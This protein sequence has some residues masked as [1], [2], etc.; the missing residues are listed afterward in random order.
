MTPTPPRFHR[1]VDPASRRWTGAPQVID[2]SESERAE[3]ARW[4][5]IPGLHSLH[6]DLEVVRTSAEAAKVSGSF[7][8]EAELVCGVSLENFVEVVTG[9]IVREFRKP[10]AA[11]LPGAAESAEIEI[12]LDAEEPGEWRQQGI[13][14]G[15]MLAEELSLAL[16]DFPR[17]PGA[18]LEDL[19]EAEAEPEPENP[20][21]VLA[22]LKD[23]KG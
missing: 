10:H 20:F 17:K 16:P 21:D 3:L 2:A 1:W 6:A 7:R 8:A 9:T 19:P 22:R 4:L 11:D 14:L 5:D 13:D 18:E 15:T 12:D 23:P